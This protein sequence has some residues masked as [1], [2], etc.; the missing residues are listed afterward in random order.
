LTGGGFRHD[1]SACSSLTVIPLLRSSHVLQRELTAGCCPK[2]FSHKSPHLASFELSHL[3]FRKQAPVIHSSR[4]VRVF[5]HSG[6]YFHVD[7]AAL[8][9]S[10]TALLLINET[11]QLRDIRYYF[12][13]L[14]CRRVFYLASIQ[15]S[16]ATRQ[17]LPVVI[18]LVTRCRLSGRAATPQPL[19]AALQ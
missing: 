16:H 4:G 13:T 7:P 3:T 15:D 1:I 11:A 12:Q 8:I 9:T 2:D 19:T 6:M 5:R 17:F 10:V 18:P 14:R